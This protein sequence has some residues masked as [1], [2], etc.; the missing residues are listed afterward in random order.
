MKL[1]NKSILDILLAQHDDSML[2]HPDSGLW[3]SETAVFPVKSCMLLHALVT[4]STV[5]LD[6]YLD[7]LEHVLSSVSE[8][9]HG[10]IVDLYESAVQSIMECYTRIDWNIVQWFLKVIKQIPITKYID[11]SRLRY[12]N[13]SV[14]KLICHARFEILAYGGNSETFPS[15]SSRTRCKNNVYRNTV[16][17]TD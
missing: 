15:N 9:N 13:V 10:W 11:I 4:S 12:G 5:I 14:E 7:K 17:F 8:S 1:S 6:C 3:L 2:S 16:Y